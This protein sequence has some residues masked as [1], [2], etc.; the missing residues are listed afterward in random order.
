MHDRQQYP[1]NGIGLAVSKRLVENHGGRIWL[2][3]AVGEGTAFY[4][5]LPANEANI[6]A[7]INENDEADES[8]KADESD[9][10]DKETICQPS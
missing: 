10:D 7:P 4:F 5:S 9:R 1:G 6:E 8:S 2:E 3:S